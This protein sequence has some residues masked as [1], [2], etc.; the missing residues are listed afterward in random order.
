MV[1]CVMGG[2]H[3]G[4]TAHALELQRLAALLTL[5]LTP[6]I[7]ET[8]RIR[9]EDVI[10]AG[11]TERL[12]AVFI[13]ITLFLRLAGAGVNLPRREL[14]AV[15]KLRAK[16]LLRL[17]CAL[18]SDVSGHGLVGGE[19]GDRNDEVFFEAFGVVGGLGYDGDVGEDDAFVGILD[20]E[21]KD[22]VVFEEVFDGRDDVFCL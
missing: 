14:E 7:V 19:F 18:E 21:L 13:F 2:G 11:E 15:L 3:T 1:D 9:R 10:C 17:F 20:V 6:Y 16:E 22:D 12:N 4:Y 8:A 5:G